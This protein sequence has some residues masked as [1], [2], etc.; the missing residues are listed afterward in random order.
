MTYVA[1]ALDYLHNGYS[2]PLVH[3]D[4]K[5]SNVLLDQNMVGHLS[6]FGI[7]KLLGI[8]D[9]PR[10]TKTI[11][12]IGYIAPGQDGLVSTSCDVYNFGVVMLEA[13]MRRRPDDEMFTGDLSIRNWVNDSFSWSAFFAI[14]DKPSRLRKQKSRTQKMSSSRSREDTRERDA[15]SRPLIVNACPHSRTRKAT[16]LPGTWPR[17]KNRKID[18]DLGDEVKG[19][20]KKREQGL[21]GENLEPFEGWPPP[22]AIS[23]GSMMR[24]LRERRGGLLVFGGQ[25]DQFGQLNVNKGLN[26]G[27]WMGFD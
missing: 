22:W 3:C 12:T 5:P 23:G 16:G 8:E 10:Q 17:S 19:L 11:G 15:L 2:E 18:G 9:S 27:H 25:G 6:D 26:P 21:F 7:A 13:F 4:L 24:R 1:S 14:A 20:G